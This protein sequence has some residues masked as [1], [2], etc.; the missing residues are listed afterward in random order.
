MANFFLKTYG[1]Q[2]NEADSAELARFLTGLGGRLVACEAE[3]DLILVNTSSYITD[4]TF[5]ALD[6][7]EIIVMVVV[8]EIAAVRAARSFL[9]LMAELGLQVGRTEIVLNRYD[10]NAILTIA[11]ISDSLGRKVGFTLNS[12]Y[13]MASRA[14]N[15]GVP[16]M[17]EYKNFELSKQI[18]SLGEYLVRRLGEIEPNQPEMQQS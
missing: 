1:C 10:P 2:A 8:Q 12:D 18:I 11:K 6:V 5:V 17:I 4:A 16:F 14:A 3:A 13:E 9:T 15:L 7:A